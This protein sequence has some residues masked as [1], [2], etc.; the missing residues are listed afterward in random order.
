[1]NVNT[2][3][4]NMTVLNVSASW[5]VGYNS[6]DDLTN[7]SDFIGLIE[8]VDVKSVEPIMSDLEGERGFTLYLTTYSAKILDDVLLSG[9]EIIEVVMTGKRGVFQIENDPLMSVGEKWFIF[10]RENADCTYAI[11]SGPNGRFVYDEENL[12]LT[13]MNSEVGVQLHGA[14]MYTVRDEIISCRRTN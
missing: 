1:M 10:A 2:S 8:V 7:A 13:S 9:K 12:S 14:N 6:V 11:L 5:A 4:G 3:D